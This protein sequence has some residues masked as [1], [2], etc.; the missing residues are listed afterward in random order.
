MVDVQCGGCLFWWISG[1]VDV[2][3]Y[4]RY[5]G[6]PVWLISG[7]VDVRCDGCPVWWMSSVVDVCVVGVVQSEMT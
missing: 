3:F 4:K 2:L 7:V 1:V 5:D 6:C